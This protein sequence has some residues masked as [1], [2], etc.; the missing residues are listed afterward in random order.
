MNVLTYDVETLS[1]NTIIPIG[2]AC[3]CRATRVDFDVANWLSRFP[4]SA[5][6][7]YVKTAG[8]TVYP[9]AVTIKN[10]IASWTLTE[11]D[12]VDVGYGQ[13][14]VALI[15]ANGEK[16]LSSVARTYLD[17][18]LI[19]GESTDLP[20]S[21]WPWV[22]QVTAA[23]NGAVRFDKEQKL[24]DE[25]KTQARNNLGVT[26]SGIETELIEEAVAKYLDENPVDVGVNF[27]V[28]ENTLRL[29]DGVLSV[30]T[31]DRMEAD[32]TQPITS[33]GVYTQ[34]GNINALLATI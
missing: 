33:A 20:P 5:I 21:M 16:K 28:D 32:N 2:H 4:N 22:E 17:K 34:V 9:A 30:N 31:T 12:T 8:G 23:G 1:K 26:E 10:G 29:E 25:Q 14:E 13:V 3:E 11:Y 15:G 7:L 18:S 6:L 24:T 27:E 19:D